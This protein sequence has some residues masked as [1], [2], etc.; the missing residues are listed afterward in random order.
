M[1]YRMNSVFVAVLAVLTLLMCA[2]A[3]ANSISVV[4]FRNDA[5][6]D[7]SIDKIYTH[8]I[9]G[10]NQGAAVI[11]GVTFDEVYPAT[12]GITDIDLS[13]LGFRYQVTS[14]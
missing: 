10:G 2:T 1:Q 6:S 9:D 7:I 3:Q 4:D 14:D 13:A 12:T 5:E 8:K 11:N